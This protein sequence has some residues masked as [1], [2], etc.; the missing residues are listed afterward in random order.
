MWNNRIALALMM[1]CG[2]AWSSLAMDE[3]YELDDFNIHFLYQQGD[4]KAFKNLVEK[5]DLDVDKPNQYG[6]CI[7]HLAAMNGQINWLDLLYS[8]DAD[9]DSPGGE[10]DW[11]PIAWAL[12]REQIQAFHTLQKFG[13]KPVLP[14][15]AQPIIK[16]P[17]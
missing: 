11:P 16:T 3:E 4:L 6:L 17:L 2:L 10:W 8:L 1:S 15:F 5:L 14:S 7:A 9:L 12:Y 13:I